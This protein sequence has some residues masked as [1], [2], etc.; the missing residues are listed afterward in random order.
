MKV[1]VMGAGAVGCYF[2]ARLRQMGHDVT[3]IGRAATV[4]AIQAHGLRLQMQ[5]R[6]EQLA[7]QA[8]TQPAAVEGA[9]LVLF[10]VKSGDTESAGASIRPFVTRACTILCLQNGVDNAERLSQVL[11]FDA[12]PAAVYVAVSMVGPGHVAHHG[13]GELIIGPS[14]GSERAALAFSQA[15]VPAQVTPAVMNALWA[16]LTANCA[17]NALSALTQLPYGELVRREGVEES[18]RAVVAECSAVATAAG[19]TLPETLW[20][21]VY[22][23]SQSM[24]GQL[25]STAQDVARG[26]RSEIDFIN[27]YVVR[28]AQRLGIEAPVN[29]LLHALVKIKDDAI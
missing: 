14:P 2:G 13:R 8:S 11:A 27:G 4:N 19:V 10:C 17:Y 1:T 20:E 7:I 5:G 3:L 25:S 23:L 26:R 15:G 9:D 18:L 21:D 22:G 6:D 29:R 12:V 28:Q 16:K 24:A